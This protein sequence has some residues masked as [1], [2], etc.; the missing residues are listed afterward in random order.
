MAKYRFDEIAINSTAKKKPVDE[1]KYT[2]LGLEHLDGGNLQVTRFGADVAPIGEKLI[3]KKGDVLFGKRRAYQKKVAI[4]PFDGIFSAHGM[5][6]RPKEDVINKDFFPFFISSDYFLDEAIKISVGSLSPTIN[7]RDLKQLEFD[8]PDMAEQERLAKILWAVEDVKQKALTS[9]T[10]TDIL[11]NSHI[12]EIT[13]L[14][15]NKKIGE[16]FN[17]VNGF[18]PSR[19]NQ[20]FWNDGTIPW[21][22]IED[23]N[24]QGGRISDTI[25]YITTSALAKNSKRLL[26]PGTL[27]LCCTA[28]V[29]A[30]ALSEIEVTTN[31]QFNGLY[32]N[33]KYHEKINM[34][35]MFYIAPLFKNKLLSFSGKT[36]IDFISVS[37]LSDLEFPLPNYDEQLKWV[38]MFKALEKQNKKLTILR[39]NICAISKKLIQRRDNLV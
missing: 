1:D 26:P 28:S 10:N 2:Y 19:S 22:T 5:V 3:M 17:I 34:D 37:T 7:W 31:Q 16:C 25:Q 27:L 29:G 6:L 38:T 11:I 9:L 39:D 35:F 32:P 30:Y 4:A 23:I 18:T 8:L 15:D 12:N 21:F 20:V 24:H 14:Y 13:K 36:T 33:E